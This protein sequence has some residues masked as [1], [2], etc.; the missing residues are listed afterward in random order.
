MS[1]ADD[2]AFLDWAQ[3]A[4]LGDLV[5]PTLKL[6]EENRMSKKKSTFQDATIFDNNLKDKTVEVAQPTNEGY[7]YSPQMNAALK[8]AAGYVEGKDY[9]NDEHCN[10][11]PTPGTS[12]TEHDETD[13][14]DAQIVKTRWG[15]ATVIIGILSLTG[16]AAYYIHVAFLV[17]IFNSVSR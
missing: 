4:K 8:N 14:Y 17:R 9:Y 3:D 7:K 15:Y 13:Q 12:Y 11:G 5:A 6:K 10:A 1:F 16:I 2:T